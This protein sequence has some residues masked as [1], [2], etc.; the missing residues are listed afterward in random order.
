MVFIRHPRTTIVPAST[1]THLQAPRCD[2]HPLASLCSRLPNQPSPMFPQRGSNS[3]WQKMHLAV[4]STIFAPRNEPIFVHL[5]G[6]PTSR[7]L[8]ESWQPY[9]CIGLRPRHCPGSLMVAIRVV[10][11][12]D[13]AARQNYG[14]IRV[15]SRGASTSRDIADHILE[16]TGQWSGG[17]A[18][19]H[20]NIKMLGG[21]SGEARPLLH[22]PNHPHHRGLTAWTVVVLDGT[23]H[24]GLG[25]YYAMCKRRKVVVSEA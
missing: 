12:T 21:W 16:W 6:S 10:R 20:A 23:E 7:W 25:E 17:R 2:P 14:L 24:Q 19:Q 8:R 18:V 15:C 13:R 4:F 5:V 3:R 9:L 11:W 1:T 22:L